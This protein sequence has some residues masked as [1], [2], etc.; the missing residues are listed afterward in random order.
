VALPVPL[1]GPPTFEWGVLFEVPASRVGPGFSWVVD[2]AGRP[3][4]TWRVVG[5]EVVRSTTCV[6]LVGVQQ[7]PDWDQ[8]RSDAAGWWRHDTVW[9]APQSGLV[10]R[11]E[12]EMKR[13]EAAR[14]LPTYQSITRY[15]LDVRLTY[16]GAAFEDRRREIV[17]TQ[18]FQ[19]EAGPLLAEP[20]RYQSHLDA[21]LRKMAYF[22]KE[23]PAIPPYRQ[24]L[25]QL[26]H[27]VEAARRGEVRA[28]MTPALAHSAPLAHGQKAPDFAV[29]DLVTRQ[30]L[31]LYE[32]LGQPV[33]L[34]FYDPARESG[35]RVL[36][37]ATELRKSQPGVAVVG[38]AMTADAELVRRQHAEMRLPFRVADGRGLHVAFG[39]DGTPRLVLLDGQGVVH[40]A[41]TGWGNQSP[42]EVA[43]ELSRLLGKR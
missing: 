26:Q 23:S 22:V 41:Q 39:V 16:P 32:Y 34:V 1:D 4:R 19:E 20:A 5:T 8:P 37:F 12:R 18:R 36:E 40:Y 11:V 14:T 13:R 15:E 43:E 21:L 3:P 10:Y 31:H 30:S 27:R 29:T 17:Q 24:A 6:K 7:S 42:G 35:R 9:V 38:L 25:L 28:E 2:E 33:L